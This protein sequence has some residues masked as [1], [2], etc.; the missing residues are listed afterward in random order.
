MLIKIIDSGPGIPEG[1]EDRIFDWL[2]TKSGG[3][4]IGLS[5]C[6]MLVESWQG[7]ISAYSADANLD[8][9][10]GAVFELK[11]KSTKL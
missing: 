11:L 6:R 3:M 7:T 10:S 5:L 4:G 9:L 1:Q 8:G 2:E